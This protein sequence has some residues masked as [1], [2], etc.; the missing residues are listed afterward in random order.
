[1]WTAFQ[2]DPNTSDPGHY[3][4]VMGRLKGGV[5]VEQARAAFEQSTQA[6][7][8]RFPDVLQEEGVFDVAPAREAL[9]A[10]ARPTLVVLMGAVGFVLLIACANVANLLLV[11]ATVRK[12]EIALTRRSAPAPAA[13]CGG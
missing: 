5:S 10:N 7:R 11:R 13:S 4:Q 1:M 2:F 6:Y 3:F 12:R 9:V 8:A